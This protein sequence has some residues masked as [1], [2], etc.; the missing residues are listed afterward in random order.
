M[1]LC[2]MKEFIMVGWI[3]VFNP[4]INQ[5]QC[6]YMNEAPI[7][8]YTEKECHSATY[9]KVNEIGDKLTAQGIKITELQMWCTVD[10]T[11]LNT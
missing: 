7:K 4:I 3:C 1:L 2:V 5:E 10:K 6:A 9:K 11:K 8:F